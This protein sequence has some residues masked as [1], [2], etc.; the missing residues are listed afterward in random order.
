MYFAAP[1]NNSNKD[2]KLNPNTGDTLEIIK[3]YSSNKIKEIIYYK[4]NQPDSNICY[5]QNG[6]TINKPKLIYSKLDK[7]LFVFIPIRKLYSNISIFFV[8]TGS[9][10][11][12]YLKTISLFQLS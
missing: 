12:L 8:N 6:G 7:S 4:N 1:P 2:I 3:R 5:L 11:S 10:Q 9:V